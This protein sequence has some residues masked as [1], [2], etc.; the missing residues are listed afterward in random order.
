[1][2]PTHLQVRHSGLQVGRPI[3]H[4]GAAVDQPL[5]M[6]SHKRLPHCGCEVRVRTVLWKGKQ[7]EEEEE[8]EEKHD[9]LLMRL[10]VF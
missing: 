8:E 3:D 5:V 6:Q 9:K 10:G 4:V 2:A 1:M 7:R